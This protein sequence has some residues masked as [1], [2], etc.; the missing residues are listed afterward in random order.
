[1]SPNPNRAQR[2]GNINVRLRPEEVAYLSEQAERLDV[3][4]S[5][6]VRVAIARSYL[7]DQSAGVTKIET[8]IHPHD[9]TLLDVEGDNEVGEAEHADGRS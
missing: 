2:T 6:A 8:W 9:D 7:T 3:S 4:L 1:M 5:E